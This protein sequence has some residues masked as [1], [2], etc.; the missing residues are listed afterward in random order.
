MFRFCA[1]IAPVKRRQTII[2]ITFLARIQ[3]SPSIPKSN[4]PQTNGHWLFAFHDYSPQ[5]S[6]KK[7]RP[8]VHLFLPAIASH[9][10]KSRRR[11]S[12]PQSV[13]GLHRKKEFRIFI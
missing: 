3:S 5:L 8:S 4:Q 7:R 6:T 11:K 13:F 12:I 2:A 9:D 10:S 1:D